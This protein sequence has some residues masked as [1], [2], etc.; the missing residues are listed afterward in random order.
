MAH[1]KVR[2]LPALVVGATAE[3]PDRYA[4]T[5][6]RVGE[7]IA[8]ARNC[9]VHSPAQIAQLVASIREFGWTTPILVD[10]AGTIVAGHGRVMAAKAMECEWVPCLTVPGT[11]SRAQCRAYAIADNK[12]ALNAGWD[13]GLLAAELREL[14]TGELPLTLTGFTEREL[15]TMAEFTPDK[16]ADG[17]GFAVV[18]ECETREAQAEAMRQIAELGFACRVR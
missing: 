3:E 17:R 4:V 10:D 11:W 16:T 18:V 15:Q 9:R 5:M 6:R 13:V 2:H 1:A 7:L 12:L 8:N 14:D